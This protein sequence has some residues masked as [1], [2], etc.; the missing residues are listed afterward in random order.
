MY[1][2]S[3]QSQHYLKNKAA[4]NQNKLLNS[5]DNQTFLPEKLIVVIEPSKS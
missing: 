4:K 3:T 5:S 2:V 1:L